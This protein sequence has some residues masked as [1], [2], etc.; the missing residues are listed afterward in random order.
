M[1]F[2]ERTKE[3]KIKSV[4]PE[5]NAVQT[6][7]CPY[8]STSDRKVPLSPRSEGYYKYGPDPCTRCNGNKQEPGVPGMKCPKCEGKGGQP[9]WVERRWLHCD[10][11]GTDFSY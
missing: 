8:C 11:C 9:H 4:S 3:A 7:Y 10:K 6:R 1:V 2:A 5:V